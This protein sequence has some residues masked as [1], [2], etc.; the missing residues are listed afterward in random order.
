VMVMPFYWGTSEVVREACVSS[1]GG[2][3]EAT[4]YAAA[5]AVARK[6]AERVFDSV[7]SLLRAPDKKPTDD[8][9][10]KFL[11]LK[12]YDDE[13]GFTKEPM[14]S[15]IR[16]YVAMPND[17]DADRNEA[18]KKRDLILDMMANVQ[19]RA[20]LVAS[21]W[22]KRLGVWVGAPLSYDATTSVPD[23]QPT[24]VGEP[25][26]KIRPIKP[27]VAFGL[28]FS[29]NAYFSILAGFTASTVE[30][31]ALGDDPLLRR[32]IWSTTLAIGGTLDIAGALTK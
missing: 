15:S 8:D 1:W 30:R 26:D 18:A 31:G 32:T 4:S 28:G 29:P 14:I 2:G 20:S 13:V 9:I 25:T 27:I 11:A 24:T 21:C 22:H 6:R 17:T 5:R 10:V 3:D 7:V 16:E 23:P 19:W 12:Y